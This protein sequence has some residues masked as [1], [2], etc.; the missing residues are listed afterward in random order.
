MLAV[1]IGNMVN[2]NDQRH[3]VAIRDMSMICALDY[4][5]SSANHVA[6]TCLQHS[7]LAL[8]AEN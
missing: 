7:F 8:Q 6:T 4:L 3:S 2:G 1:E 5:Q